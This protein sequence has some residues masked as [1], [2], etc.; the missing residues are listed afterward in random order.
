MTTADLK[1][2][3]LPEPDT[4]CF[5]EDTC[6]DVWSYSAE[7]MHTFALAHILA[8]RERCA[9]IARYG[10]LVPPDGGSPTD[11]ERVLCDEIEFRIRG[12]EAIREGKL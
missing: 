12:Y 8:E 4:H 10:C 6:K 11:D 2:L 7:Q 1:A 3:P 5:D 9:L